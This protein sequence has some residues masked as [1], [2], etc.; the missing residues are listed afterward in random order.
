MFQLKTQD[1][2]LVRSLRGFVYVLTKT[3]RRIAIGAKYS[4]HEVVY[5]E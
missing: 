5:A 4:R 1:N 2:N 3:V